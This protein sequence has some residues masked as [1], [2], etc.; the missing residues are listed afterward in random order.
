[1]K[2]QFCTLFDKNYLYRG[3]ALYRSLVEN[4]DDFTLWVLCMDDRTY[5]VLKSI[6]LDRMRLISLSAFEDKEL[7]SIKSSRTLKEYCWTCTS[8]LQLYLLKKYPHLE[9]ITYLDAD[10]FFFSDPLPIFEEFGDSSIL[11]S[12][13]NYAPQHDHY[14][15]TSGIY[16]VQFMTFKNNVQGLEALTWWREKCLEW[17]YARVE[18]GRFGD[19]K[20]LDDW[21]TRFSG[22]HVLQHIGAGVALWN[23]IKYKI[24]QIGT[25]IFV[26]DKPLIFYH[27]HN[28]SILKNKSYDFGDTAHYSNSLTQESIR[29]IYKPYVYE[30]EK[31]IKKVK[32]I[33]PK[34][35]CGYRYVR[36]GSLIGRIVSMPKRIRNVFWL[37]LNN[38]MKGR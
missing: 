23:I 37:M 17:C 4:C 34:F 20:Y 27:F 21:P 29:L 31:S 24:K 35:N 25:K 32:K 8:S 5:Q 10:L 13:H 3:L 19:Q 26:D 36:K 12:P 30:I 16:C 38:R 7:L 1:M 2:Y 28:F 18:D 15:A 6:G 33:D 11:I 9:M 22:V 14:L